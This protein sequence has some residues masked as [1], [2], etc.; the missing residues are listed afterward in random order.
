[1]NEEQNNGID[2][3]LLKRRLLIVIVVAL[4]FGSFCASVAYRYRTPR[5][6][7]SQ[8]IRELT[9][10]IE[11]QTS[12]PISSM[13]RLR[14]GTFEVETRKPGFSGNTFR[15]TRSGNTLQVVHQSLWIE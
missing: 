11:Q 15:I 2:S 14:S 3:S 12:E 4:V 8:E 5:P 9:A 6:L 13:Q 7:T 1:M 10:V